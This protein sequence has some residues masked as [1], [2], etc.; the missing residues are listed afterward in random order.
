MKNIIKHL[1]YFLDKKIK[2][3]LLIFI[4][5]SFIG[6][7][8]ETLSIGIIPVFISIYIKAGFFYDN[9]PIYF[10][11]SINQISLTTFLVV[12]SVSVILLFILKNI[13][14]YLIHRLYLVILNN[15][16]QKTTFKI[17]K[18]F[19]E[20]DFTNFKK[21]SLGEKLRDLT[22]EANNSTVAIMQLMSIIQDVITLT[23]IIVLIFISSNNFILLLLFLLFLVATL[24]LKLFSMKLKKIGHALIASRQNIF[25]MIYQTSNLIRE[26]KINSKYD[27]FLNIFVLEHKKLIERNLKKLLVT[28]MP[29]Y[30]FEVSGIIFVFMIIFYEIEIIKNNINNILPLLALIIISSARI[31]PITTALIQKLSNAKTMNVSFDLILNILKKKE[32]TV[33]IKKKY[34]HDTKIIDKPIIEIKNF[35]FGYDDQ[36]I[37]ENQNIKIEKNSAIGILGKSGSGKSTLIDIMTGMIEVDSGDIYFQGKKVDTL[38]EVD[39]KISLVSQNPQLLNLSIIEN[40]AFGV[41]RK[42]IDIDKVY[43]I[44][45]KTNLDDLINSKKERAEF[46]VGDN[47]NNLSGGQIQRIAIARALY[48]DPKIIFFDEPTSS[49][50]EENGKI[51]NNLIYNTINQ[52]TSAV[53]ISHEKNFLDK[54]KFIYEVKDKKIILI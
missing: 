34:F 47:G 33:A 31:L 29:K 39:F 8:L 26:I 4:I 36:I 52:D 43:Q 41:D 28:S 42:D 51:I 15:I 37:F 23:C 38:K 17:Y 30:I 3:K 53:I 32:D 13:A 9:L 54:C 45:K 46:L 49:L 1:N 11:E 2:I 48:T 24:F 14:L 50:D 20:K 7:L 19:M 35:S 40:I 18:N 16:T 44:I 21:Y 5:F 27:F 22:Q 10:L 25:K 12:S 6:S